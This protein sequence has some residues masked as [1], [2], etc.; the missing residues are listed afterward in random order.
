VVGRG[1]ID[2]SGLGTNVNTPTTRR[3]RLPTNEERHVGNVV[4]VSGNLFESDSQTIVVTV[5]CVG[6]MGKGIALE[7]KERYPDLFKRYSE[8]CA[9]RKV[10][11]GRP[12]FVERLLPPS[13]LLFP[14][15]DH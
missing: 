11:L 4:L 9:A 14:T 10:Q 8:L 2:L 3:E 12:V 15:K 1:R 6:V 5:N 7:A 13:F